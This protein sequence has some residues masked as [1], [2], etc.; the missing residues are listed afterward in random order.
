MKHIQCQRDGKECD[1]NTKAKKCRHLDGLTH[2]GEK[3]P[4]VW[5]GKCF[6]RKEVKK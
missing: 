4:R 2:E 1:L 6:D 5:Q 3:Y